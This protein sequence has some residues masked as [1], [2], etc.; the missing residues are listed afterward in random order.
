MLRGNIKQDKQIVIGWEG[1]AISGRV[2][3]PL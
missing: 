2:G 3:S 1:E